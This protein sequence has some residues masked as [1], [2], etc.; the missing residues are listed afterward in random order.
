M[1][2]VALDT[3][4]PA[5][6]PPLAGV[7][8]TYADLMTHAL[9]TK[10]QATWPDVALID[11]GQGDPLQLASIADIET[12]ALTVEQGAAK[13]RAWS[14]D[15]R[16]YVTAYADRSTMP[17]VDA[18]LGGLKPF[19]WYATLDGTAHIGGLPAG[20]QPALVQ[21]LT[22]ADLGLHADLSL[23]YEDNWRPSPLAARMANLTSHVRLMTSSVQAS[24]D[25]ALADLTELMDAIHQ[26]R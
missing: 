16:P 9:L 23:V 15:H 18:Q 13:I 20:A 12:G 4:Q 1:I 7:L 19:R 2:R 6:L 17:Q 25:H 21:C 24:A 8:L 3:D 26:I 5:E 11:R 10:L 22:A 14:A